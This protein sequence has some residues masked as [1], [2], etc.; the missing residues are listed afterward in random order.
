MPSYTSIRKA[1]P[2]D[3]TGRGADSPAQ[4]AAPVSHRV[5]PQARRARS[6]TSLSTP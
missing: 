3:Y 1:T 5:G 6:S 2:T 4:P